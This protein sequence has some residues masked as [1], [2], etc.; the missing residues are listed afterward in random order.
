M[1]NRQELP[2]G[3]GQKRKI[4]LYLAIPIYLVI[5]IKLVEGKTFSI[6]NIDPVRFEFFVCRHSV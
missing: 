6:C 5:E 4:F 2:K 1:Y 3:N